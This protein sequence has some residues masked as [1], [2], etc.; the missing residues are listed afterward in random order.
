MAQFALKANRLDRTGVLTYTLAMSFCTH[1]A[2][3]L[4]LLACPLNCMGAFTDVGAQNSA[5]AACGCCGNGIADRDS[6]PP[7]VPDTPDDDCQCPTCLCN[8]AVILLDSGSLDLLSLN[9]HILAELWIEEGS[10]DLASVSSAWIDWCRDHRILHP[11]GRAARILH[12][13]FLL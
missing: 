8:G 12:Q 11:A 10:E 1:L 3:I 4:S 6:A 7:R 13:S 2:L 9:E 5:P